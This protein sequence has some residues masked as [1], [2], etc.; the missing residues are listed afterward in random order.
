[1]LDRRRN[2][3]TD[4]PSELFRQAREAR[5]TAQHA[6]GFRQYSLPHAGE[7]QR[8]QYRAHVAERLVEGADL[9]ARGVEQLRLEGVEKRMP[10]LVAH[11]VRAL[12]GKDRA[13]G[14]RSVEELQPFAV[15]TRVEVDPE[16]EVHGQARGHFP[17]CP[18]HQRAP[19]TR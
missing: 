9:D 1:G 13:S 5:R 11:D 10:E 12:A 4:G 15:L 7:L 17:A 16:P 2:R 14:G 19:D 8:R 6:A 18:R 3:L